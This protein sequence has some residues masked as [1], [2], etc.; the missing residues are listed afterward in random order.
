MIK[1]LL[2]VTLVLAAVYFLQQLIGKALI[3]AAI[4]YP[5]EIFCK[6]R[7]PEIS[8]GFYSAHELDCFARSLQ[9]YFTAIT[10][11]SLHY[12]IYG[13]QICELEVVQA[14]SGEMA[15][16][17]RAILIDAHNYLKEMRGAD[18]PDIFVPVLTEKCL[19]IL[20]ACS[21]KAHELAKKLDFSKPA[22]HHSPI[23]ET[24]D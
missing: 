3:S 20:I 16:I 18:N 23:D 9:A 24:I 12:D 10:C 7:E 8:Q 4:L 14:A 2:A 6:Y 21:P 5:L 17:R 11:T 13:W 1:L 19:V 22:K 15:E